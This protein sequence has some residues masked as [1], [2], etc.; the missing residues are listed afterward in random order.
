M[1]TLKKRLRNLV[2][3]DRALGVAAAF[4][5]TASGFALLHAL[6]GAEFTSHVQVVMG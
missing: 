6:G 5:V 1:N 2:T 4:V 3:L